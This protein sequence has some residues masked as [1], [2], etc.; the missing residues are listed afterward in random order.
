MRRLGIILAAGLLLSACASTQTTQGPGPA[1]QPETGGQAFA[2]Q[3]ADFLDIPDWRSADLAPALLAF[4]R[5]CDGRRQRA[6]D[7]ALPGGGRY[8]G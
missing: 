4:R 2:L 7:A 1:A 5:A 3:P 8:G 6:A